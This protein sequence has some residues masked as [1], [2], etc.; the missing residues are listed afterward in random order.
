[1]NFVEPR[2]WAFFLVVFLL[3]RALRHQ[4]QNITLG[5]A[6]LIFYGVWSWRYLLLMLLSALIAFTC[7]R[8]SSPKSSPSSR[9]LAVTLGI[10]LNLGILAFFKYYNFAVENLFHWLAPESTRAG[11]FFLDVILP[12]GVSFYTFQAISYIMDVYRGR[13]A[14]VSSASDFTLYLC[15]FPQLVAGPI[16]RAENL[17][18]Q[19]IRP[20]KIDFAGVQSGLLLI[21]WG[22]V[23]KI[24]IADTLALPVNRIFEQPDPT[25]PEV[26][27]GTVAF[28]FQILGDFAGYTDIARGVA[29]TLG[30]ELMLNFNLPYFAMNPADFWRRWH[31]S[32]STWLRDYLYIPLGGNKH[33]PLRT[34]RNLMLTMTLG[35]LWHGAAWNFILWGIYHGTLLAFHRLVSGGRTLPESAAAPAGISRTLALAKVLGMFQ[36]TLLGWLLFRAKSLGHIGVLT[37][38]LTR[39]WDSWQSAVS[40]AKYSA[41]WILLM[42]LHQLWEFLSRSSDPAARLKWPFRA[43]YFGLCV[44]STWI[45]N[46]SGSSPFIYFQF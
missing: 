40:V 14:P 4:G 10:G 17:L 5:I 43:A 16:E 2:F 18:P 37:D 35:G 44:W 46:R 28:A 39:N 29:R 34:Y 6:S 23:E 30:F 12:I 32:L 24:V 8:Y 36:L 19:V 22:L 33:G 11:S 26:Y 15:F 1:M 38:A 45:F 9:K 3:T 42:L 7:G 41:P 25:G 20:R 21:G 31:I 13:L 27:V